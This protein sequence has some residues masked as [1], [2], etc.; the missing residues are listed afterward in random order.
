[1]AFS[2]KKSPAWELN[3]QPPVPSKNK[4]GKFS[5]ITRTIVHTIENLLHSLTS[6][7]Q[8]H[9]W[10]NSMLL[11]LYEDQTVHTSK[12]LLH[13]FEKWFHSNLYRQSYC[14]TLCPYHKYFPH[15]LPFTMI[16]FEYFADKSLCRSTQNLTS[17]HVYQ[18]KSINA[19]F[20]LWGYFRK[21]S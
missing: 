10:L 16:S 15:F 9:T 2:K 19:N 13:L 7:S 6:R 14:F 1:M 11:V 12:C 20:G 3:L 8:C 21:F 18:C 17:N 4:I 5:H